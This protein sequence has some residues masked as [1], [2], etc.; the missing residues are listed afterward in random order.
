[1]PEKLDKMPQVLNWSSQIEV[2]AGPYSGNRKSWLSRAARK[3][4]ATFRQIKSLY[5]GECKD[6]KTSVALGVLTAAEKARREASEQASRFESL[7]GAMNASDPDFYS[8]DVLAL[9]DAA[10]TLRGFRST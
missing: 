9:I 2:I 5:Y 3:S 8:S 1:M 10:R 6:P 7:A 4:G